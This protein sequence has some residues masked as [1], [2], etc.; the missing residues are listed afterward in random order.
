M[1]SKN[2]NQTSDT[3]GNNTDLGLNDDRRM[4]KLAR[5]SGNQ[6]KYAEEIATLVEDI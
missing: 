2:Q 4:I 1:S 6:K 3:D 5:N